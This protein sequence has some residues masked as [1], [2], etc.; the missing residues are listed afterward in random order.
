MSQLAFVDFSC[1]PISFT[2]VF[3]YADSHIFLGEEGGHPN[4]KTVM[5]QR[6][7]LFFFF[8]QLQLLYETISRFTQRSAPPRWNVRSVKEENVFSTHASRLKVMDSHTWSA[9][10]KG[11]ECFAVWKAGSPWLRRAKQPFHA[12]AQTSR[13]CRSRSAAKGRF[14]WRLPEWKRKRKRKTSNIKVALPVRAIKLH[15]WHISP[16]EGWWGRSVEHKKNKSWNIKA[17]NMKMCH[18]LQFN[19]EMNILS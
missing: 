2:L 14:S 7:L 12:R 5:N 6:H 13:T 11:Q 15:P 3:T 4:N 17:N 1:R 9:G 16:S 19:A 18:G 10:E 8:P